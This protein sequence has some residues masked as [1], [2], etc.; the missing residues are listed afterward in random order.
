MPVVVVSYAANPRK[1]VG[2]PASG[3]PYRL[4]CQ[5]CQFSQCFAALA[6]AFSARLFHAA[7]HRHH[8]ALFQYGARYKKHGKGWGLFTSDWSEVLEVRATGAKC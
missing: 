5:D 2:K 7:Q 8:V 4:E 6:E 1:P 3:M